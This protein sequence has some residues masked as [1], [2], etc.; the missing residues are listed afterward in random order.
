MCNFSIVG[1]NATMGERKLYVD[2]DKTIDERNKIAKTFNKAFPSLE[3]KVGGETGIDIGCKGNDKSQIIKDFD[4]EDVLH[5]FGDAMHEGGNDY[6]LAQLV[7]NK[8]QVTSW[9]QTWEYLSWFQE[10][11]IAN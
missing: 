8:R 4:E 3:A 6:P 11:G 7:K 9:N 1:R 5:F 2:F 10:Q